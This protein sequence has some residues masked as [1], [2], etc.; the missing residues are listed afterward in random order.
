MIKKEQKYR[1]LIIFGYILFLIILFEGSARLAFII[2]RT[3]QA[4]IELGEDSTWRRN[5]VKRHQNSGMKIYYKFDV[6]DPSKGWS[7]RPNIRDM[8]VFQKKILNTNSKGFRGKKEY[9]YTKSKDKLR[10]LMLG[11]SFAFGDEVSDNETYSYYLQEILPN[12]EVINLGVHGYGHDQMLILLKEEGIKYKPDIVL[13]GFFSIDMPRNLLKFRDFAKPKF[14]LRNGELNLTGTPVPRPEDILKWDWARPRILDIFSIMHYRASERSGA[15]EKE[16][17]KITTAIML[18]MIQVIE[19]IHALPL[20]TY[21]PSGEEIS[22][23]PPMTPYEAYM[24]SMCQLNKKA[25][26]FSLRPYFAEKLAQGETFGR[27]GHWDPKSHRTAAEGIKQY[28]VD[29][30]HT[31]VP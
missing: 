22:V 11:D 24:L 19:D 23:F 31:N 10:I 6:Y 13:L 9:S 12:T 2:P 7:L 8:E 17:M 30:G 28:L 26:C 1:F 20:L 14:I 21:M 4:L 3:S 27:I 29:K 25:E 15:I 18:D 5:W 16:K